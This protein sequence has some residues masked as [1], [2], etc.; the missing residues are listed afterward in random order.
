MR[1]WLVGA[2]VA[3]VV[4]AVLTPLARRS[5]ADKAGPET[6][7][8][9]Q[10][11]S[12]GPGALAPA[13]PAAL[14]GLDLTR[15]SYDETGAATASLSDKKTAR[16]TLD[17]GLQRFALALLAVHKLPEAAIVVMETQTGR[18]LAYASRLDSGP[19]R[20]LNVEA[21]APAASVFKIVTGSS[22]VENAQLGPDTK[23]C[24]SGGEHGIEQRDLE[25]D[26][27]RDRWCTT[28]AG[29][30]GRSVNTVFARLALQKLAPAQLE[31]SARA[32]GF[33]ESLP[34]D[35]AVQQSQLNVP[36]DNLGYAR[37][38]A[39]FWNTTLS[40]VHAATLSA[41]IARGGE[42][43]RP[44]IVNDVVDAAGN[45]IWSAPPSPTLKRAMQTTT[46]Q[47]VTTMMDRTVSDGTSYRAFHDAA[48]TPFIPSVPIAGKT[49]TLTDNATGRFY[50]WFTGF[51]PS[52]TEPNAPANKKQV[53]IAVLV[54]NRPTWH[55][56]ANVLAREMLRAYF[57]D[58]KVPAP[59]PAPPA[60]AKRLVHATK[61]IAARPVPRPEAKN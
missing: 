51:G 60:N 45:V 52:R 21:T 54:V 49:G 58:A 8:L 44:M 2:G 34:F 37:M 5:L 13:P 43:I 61:G 10:H 26:P 27:K 56:K 24:Y 30:M 36:P 22:L 20:D 48:G 39:G 47:A 3:I 41:T 50:T 29:A 11:A 32:L 17:P 25:P 40:P 57:T 14:K 23:E 6:A 12:A 9:M 31:A 59:P 16:L 28:L 7:A 15:I 38:A 46:A 4:A 53:A 19:Q 33:G 1:K 18:I 55:V 35:V 42:G